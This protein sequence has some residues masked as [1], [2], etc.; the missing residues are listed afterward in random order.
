MVYENIIYEERDCV[1]IITFNREKV[2]NALNHALLREFKDVLNLIQKKDKIRVVILT[3]AGEK[4]FVAGADIAEL[5]KLSPLQTKII[6]TKGHEI[7]R[8]LECLS[9][10]VIAA[11]NGYAL[12]GGFE[13]AL[14]CDFIYASQTAS[15]GLP[16]INLGLIPGYGG[17]QRLARL[18]GKGIAKELIYTGEIIS[19]IK[20]KEIGIVNKV[21]KPEFLIE[22]TMKTAQII[23][24]KGVVALRGA[25]QAINEGLDTSL[26]SG[27]GIEINHFALVAASRD[28]R[29]GMNAFI[30]KRTA[31][32]TGSL[33]D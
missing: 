21:C 6:S 9:Q 24:S 8:T 7:L 1:G 29:E 13:I 32:F 15:F 25:K 11:V 3:G 33:D 2:M 23:S 18:I 12:G 4:S 10:P 17:T 5:L 14:A 20:A 31:N 22:E 28:S 30:E 16:E 27:I 19:A 26:S